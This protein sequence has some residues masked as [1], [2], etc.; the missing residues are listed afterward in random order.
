[1]AAA[2]GDRRDR[3]RRRAARG[4]R[5]PVRL[6]PRRRP[7]GR[8]GGRRARRAR[9][10]AADGRRRR[11][12]LRARRHDRVPR[13]P[14]LNERP[15]AS[16]VT[17]IARGCRMRVTMTGATGR[18]GDADRPRRCKA[19]G[20][21]VTVLSRNPER[22]RAALGVDAVAWRARGRAG[23]RRGAGGPRRR[24][25]PRRRGRRPALDRRGQARGSA[26]R[27]SSARATS[28][29]G[30]ARP[31]RAR[32]ALVS[33]LR[34][35]LVRPAAATSRLT[36]HEPAGDDFLA[37]VCARGSARRPPRRRS[38]CASRGSAPA[39]CSTRTA[40]RSRRCSRSFKLGVGGPVAGGR[41]YLPWIHARRP[42][43]ALPRR[44]RRRA[45]VGP[46][47][48]HARPS[49][50]RTSD[51]RRRSAARC[52]APRSRPSPASRSA[53]LYGEMADI[54]VT[55]SARC[56]A[57]PLALGFAFAPSGARRGARAARCAPESTGILYTC[58]NRYPDRGTPG[59]VESMSHFDAPRRAAP[60][61]PDRSR[62]H[63]AGRRPRRPPPRS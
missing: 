25:P 32:A 48:R 34:G 51:F 31:T 58:R 28:S 54:V 60:A 61:G 55:A 9:S 19:R 40:A 38:A 46:V 4:L 49:R 59:S 41:Q 24:D 56:P 47:Q 16:G 26:P 12:R 6:Q 53:L 18:V 11:V 63:L 42:R 50:S 29:P 45:L 44:A 1:M 20:D 30:C 13:D 15:V 10:G 39:S 2:R 36:E 52:T 22:A 17:T 35:R 57:R 5:H 62:V 14:G 37:G 27:A 21:E 3:R 8:R 7:R 43:R 33:R 23:A